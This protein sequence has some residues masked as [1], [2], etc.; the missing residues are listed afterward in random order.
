MKSKGSKGSKGFVCLSLMLCVMIVLVSGFVDQ[1]PCQEKYP[2]KAIDVILPAA[3]GAANDLIC[4]VAVQDLKKKW[5]VPINIINK[6]GGASVAGTLEALNARPDG[7]TMMCDSVATSGAMELSVKQ[8]NIKIPDRTRIA[9]VAAM[10]MVM[11]VAASSPYKS[12]KDVAADAKK[13]PGSFTWPSSGGNSGM[14]I[15]AR[16]FYKAIGVNVHK[17][18]P[19]VAQSAVQAVNLLGSGSLKMALVTITA[20]KPQMDAGIIR[21]LATSSQTRLT[22]YPNVPTFAE[23]GYPAVDEVH[24]LGF[25]GPAKLPENIVNIWSKALVEGLKDPS[26]IS[27]LKNVGCYP[28]YHNPAEFEKYVVTE[29]VHL[30]ELFEVK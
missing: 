27:Q 13:D 11:V 24:W 28:Y 7:Y 22:D 23:S 1:A 6:P 9:M 17:T 2:T 19:V 10:P 16:Q 29:T 8:Q 25:S 14:D 18:K 4:R 3:A 15:T 20:A 12:V 30:K 5:G 26:V 21:A